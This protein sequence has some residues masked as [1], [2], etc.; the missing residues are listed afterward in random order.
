M[1]PESGLYILAAVSANDSPKSK[2]A[3][4]RVLARD[5]MGGDVSVDV[6]DVLGGAS[7][8]DLVVLNG[9]V[10]DVFRREVRKGDIAVKGD[11]V[12]RVGTVDDLVGPATRRL[13]AGG[14]FITPGLIDTHAHSYHANLSMTEYARACLRTGTT[15]VAEGFYGQGQI[16]GAHAVRFFYDELRLTPLTVLFVVPVLAYLQNLELGLPSTPDS[17]TGEQLLEMLD[18]EGCVG[19]EEPPWIPIKER[20]PVIMRLID[21][22]HRRGLVFMGHAAGLEGD[23][24]VGD[25]SA[26][27]TGDHECVTAEEAISRLEQG[28]M[29]SMRETPIARNQRNVQRAITELGADPALFMFSSDVPDAVTF[30]RVGHIDEQIRI[31]VGG[32]IDPLDAIRM[33]TINAARYYRVDHRIGSLTPGRQADI[34]LVEDLERF[35]ASTVIA[36]GEVIVGPEPTARFERPIYP[37]FLTNTVKLLR[38]VEVEDLVLRVP[39]D[40]T[41]ATVRVIGAESLLSDE[42][43]VELD[44][45]DGVVQPDVDADVLKIAMFDRYARWAEPAIA[46]VQGFRLRRGAIGQSY[47]PYFNDVMVL[48]TNDP[49][50]ALA[51]NTVAEVGGGFVAVAEGKVLASLSLPLCGV[52]S[53]R[54]L[55]EVVDDL[56]R[57]YTFRVGGAWSGD[58]MAIPQSCFRGGRR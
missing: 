40:A 50:M 48:G 38:R 7:T 29:V 11:R 6:L 13:D 17:V 51:A 52:M 8:A 15:A 30:A 56:E 16:R 2:T 18:W 9:Q 36:K 42:R 23:D 33:A 1:P 39:Q 44:V 3:A 54:P 55:D 43:H 25:A 45:V 19:I 32:G 5:E 12:V 37:A 20:D 35:E 27:V 53:D 49:D 10:V 24:L 46:F 41:R 31:A 28:I 47:N 34:L 26:G 22:T 4:D 57:L 21:E 14:R 58:P